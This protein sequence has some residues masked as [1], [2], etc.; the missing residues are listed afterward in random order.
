VSNS[1]EARLHIEI[2]LPHASILELSLECVFIETIKI[3]G[4][5]FGMSREGC[6]FDVKLFDVLVVGLSEQTSY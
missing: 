4:S 6:G 2:L 3:E 1:G 5:I